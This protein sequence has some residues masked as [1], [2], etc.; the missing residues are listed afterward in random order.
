MAVIWNIKV[1]YPLESSYIIIS[2]NRLLY[3]YSLKLWTLFSIKFSNDTLWKTW[4]KS[5]TAPLT[6]LELYQCDSVH[7][8]IA[9]EYTVKRKL[10][11][12]LQSQYVWTR[13]GCGPH[14][15]G[16]RKKSNWYCYL[17]WLKHHPGLIFPLKIF[18]GN[19]DDDYDDDGIVGKSVFASGNLFFEAQLS[20]F[21]GLTFRILRLNFPNFPDELSEFSG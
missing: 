21:W 7:L 17:F 16:W 9:N 20:E 15:V 2:I 3:I 10:Y 14:I 8:R 6:Y 12:Y 13:S 11:G 1:N 19:T 4:R 5:W 18:F